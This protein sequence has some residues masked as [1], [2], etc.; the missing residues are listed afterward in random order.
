MRGRPR[1]LMQNYGCMTGWGKHFAIRVMQP[2]LSTITIA[3]SWVNKKTMILLSG[4]YP[5]KCC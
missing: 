5:F 1:M 4:E 3:I 2:M